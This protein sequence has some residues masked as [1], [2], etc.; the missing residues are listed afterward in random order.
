MTDAV[1]ATWQD[2]EQEATDELVRRE[3][4]DALPLGTIAAVVLVAEG[5]AS[6][7]E[8]QQAAVGDGDPVG[9]AR[10]IGEHGLG[11]GER[12]LG[13]D[14]EALLPDRGEMAQEEAAVGE[15]GLRAEERKSSRLMEFE[16]PGEE[17]A[18]EERA[19]HPHRQEEG[20]TR[21]YPA[22]PV[23]RDAA[24]RHDHVDM[25]MVCHRRSPGVEHGGDG[26]AGAEVLHVTRDRHHRL[27][28]RAEQQIVDDRLV[29]QGDVCDLGGQREDDMEVA[30]RQQVGLALGQPGARGAALAF[31]TVPVA[32]ANGERPLAAL[33]ADPVMGSWQRLDR[34]MMSTAAAPTHHYEGRLRSAI[35]LSDGWN[36]PRRKCGGT[37]DSMASSFSVGSPRV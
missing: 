10:E 23:E 4:H 20:R 32:A 24:A 34:A 1:E 15:T 11:A 35:N 31:G 18:A 16:Q 33:W 2:M 30:D 29:V 21:R 19:Q 3:R 22:P 37:I 14:Y 28:C 17:Q 7:V 5:D 8:R 26:D 13:I 25:G 9:I 6:L 12:R 27:R 36:T